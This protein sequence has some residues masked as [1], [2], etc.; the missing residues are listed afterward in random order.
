MNQPVA[1]EGQ[2]AVDSIQ[3]QLVDYACTLHFDKLPP[4]VVHAARVRVIDT[5]GALIGGFDGDAC[6]IAR[7]VAAAVPQ[8]GGA[9]VIGTQ[10]KTSPDL[11]AYVNAT[12]ARYVEMNDT[13][14][15]PGSFGGHP[16]DVLTPLLGVAEHVRASGREFLAAVV[17]AYEIYQGFSDAFHNTGRGFDHTNLC[18]LGVALGAGRLCDLTPAQL[19]HCVALAAVPNV[20]LRQV[21]IDHYSMYKAAASGHAGR[22]GVFAAMLARAGMEGPH[23]PFAG[24]AGWCAQ[25]AREP[26]APDFA[27]FGAPFR[28]SRTVIKPRACCGTTIASALAAEQVAPLSDLPAVKKVVVEAYKKARDEFG[29]G[30]HRWHPDTRETADHSIPYVVAVT[31]R[32]G[33]VTPR[34]FDEVNLRDQQLHALMQKIEVVENPQFTE[35]YARIPVEHRSRVTIEFANG[36]RR[37]GE[38]GGDTNELSAPKTD[39]EISEK[40]RLLCEASLGAQRV[41]ALLARLWAL[42]QVDDVAVIPPEFAFE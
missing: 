19:S 34:S 30:A 14:H 29:S 9:T 42:D 23:L 11:A 13:Y 24:A 27:S 26:F 8:A 1:A 32:D 41:D 7:V 17:L 36:E 12:T 39:R 6:R 22:A 18:T 38:A 10:L 37:V 33:A 16:S 20:I 28:I 21:R 40:F 2:R 3:S 35:A 25:V 5:L 31:L 4:A 15:W